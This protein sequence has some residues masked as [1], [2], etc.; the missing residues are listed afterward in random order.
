MPRL[1]IVDYLRSYAGGAL[2]LVDHK[3]ADEAA[4]EITRLREENARLNSELSEERE[5]VTVLEDELFL[6]EQKDCNE[7]NY[8]QSQLDAVVIE[9]NTLR[10]ENTRLREALKPFAE[11]AADV[12]PDDGSIGGC[13]CAPALLRPYFFNAA[14]AIRETSK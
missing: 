11:K 8:L 4:D 3:R 2:E 13:L 9:R 1:E 12:A 6:L 10:E 7:E 5:R 14:A